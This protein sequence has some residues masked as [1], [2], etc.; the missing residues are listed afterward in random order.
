[1]V[2]S[3]RGVGFIYMFSVCFCILVYIFFFLVKEKR[4]EKKKRGSKLKKGLKYCFDSNVALCSVCA[5][6]GLSCLSSALA[7]VG[8]PA[9]VSCSVCL[10][11]ACPASLLPVCLSVCLSG[12]CLPWRIW[13]VKHIQEK[14]KRQTN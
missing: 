6:T 7:E 13:L 11:A 9:S 12:F 14:T 1:M 3:Q 10:P 8:E 2:V 4:K 5:Q